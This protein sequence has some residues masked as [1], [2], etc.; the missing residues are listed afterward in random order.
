[1]DNFPVS[2]DQG[3]KDNDMIYKTGSITD[4]YIK[5]QLLQSED[6]IYQKILKKLSSKQ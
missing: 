4:L 1:M 5:Y 2:I 3:I 6:I